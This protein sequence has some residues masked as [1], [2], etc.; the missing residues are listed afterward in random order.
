MDMKMK[1]KLRKICFGGFYAWDSA[2][3]LHPSLPRTITFLIFQQLY[4]I[5][6]QAVNCSM[7]CIPGLAL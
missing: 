3:R 6:E 2:S 7:V 5:L 4:Q 1:K